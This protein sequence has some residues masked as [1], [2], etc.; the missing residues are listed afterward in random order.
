MRSVDTNVLV[1]IITR[2]DER[3]TAAAEAFVEPGAW[4]PMLAL[5]EAIW[6]LD[7]VYN[8]TPSQLATAL[9]ML[10]DHRSLTVQDADLVRY[11]LALFR[12]KPALG[13]Y[14]CVMLESARRAGHLPLGTFD[15]RL[16]KLAGTQKL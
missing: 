5:V 7:A 6:V 4:V 11:A 16:A 8:R 3:Q 14:D 12:A 9:E 1:R 10:L 13:F 2:D 15:Y